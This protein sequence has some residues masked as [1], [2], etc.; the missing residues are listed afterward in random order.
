MSVLA[1][2]C[3]CTA[4]LFALAALAQTQT[5]TP[6]PSGTDKTATPA[7][8]TAADFDPRELLGVWEGY[9]V[10]GDGSKTSQRTGNVSLTI[11]ADKITTSI[12]GNA[13]E[14]TYRISAGDG[15][16]RQIDATGTGGHYQ[17]KVYPGIFTLEGNTLKW[18]SGEAGWPRP[19]ALRTHFAG[20][21]YLM[22]LTRKQ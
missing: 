11:T 7:I 5:P 1:S 12:Q 17:G 6:V 20:G 10:D 8:P 18:C 9:L 4:P 14:G 16:L 19:T 2:L 22:I 21:Q 13:G 3:R 15:K